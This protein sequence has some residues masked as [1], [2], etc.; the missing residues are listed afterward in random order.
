[1]AMTSLSGPTV[2]RTILRPSLLKHQLML[3]L[4]ITCDIPDS[5]LLADADSLFSQLNGGLRDP[6]G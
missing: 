1:M 4:R 6:R 3:C 5:P 2:M